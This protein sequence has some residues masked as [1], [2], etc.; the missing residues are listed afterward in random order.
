MVRA[1]SFEEEEVRIMTYL[2]E[3]QQSVPRLQRLRGVPRLGRGCTVGDGVQLVAQLAKSRGYFLFMWEAPPL[4]GF[5][6]VL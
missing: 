6:Q 3:G 4:Q 5:E 1:P 2:Y